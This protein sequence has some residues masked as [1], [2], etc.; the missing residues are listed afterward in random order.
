MGKQANLQGPTAMQATGRRDTYCSVC[1]VSER[2]VAEHALQLVRVLEPTRLLQYVHGGIE[3][4]FKG[5]ASTPISDE[6]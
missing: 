4:V 5:K 6:S 3:T 2:N 1:L